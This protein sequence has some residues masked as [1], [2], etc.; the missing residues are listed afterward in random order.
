MI[1]YVCKCCGWTND[2]PSPKIQTFLAI[3]RRNTVCCTDMELGE[4]RC[5]GHKGWRKVSW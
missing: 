5:C 4:Y 1:E 2:V 3:R